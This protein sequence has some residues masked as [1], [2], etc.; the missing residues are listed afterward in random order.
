MLAA[1]RRASSRV[2]SL[3]ADSRPRLF[4]EVDVGQLLSGAVLHDEAGFQFLDGPGRRET[5]F[6]HWHWASQGG[7]DALREILIFQHW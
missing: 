2:S 3:A 7:H 5:A 1:M 6:R 4:L